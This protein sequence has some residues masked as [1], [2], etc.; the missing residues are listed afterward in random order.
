MIY[1]L[2]GCFIVLDIITGLV[3]ALKNKNYSSTVMREGLFHK[4]S[5]II[6][7]V[8]A[9]II[10]YSSG[11]VDIGFSVAINTPICCYIMLME[12]GSIIENLKEIN[13]NLLTE[14]ITQYFISNKRGE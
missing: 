8:L 5:E 2:V 11:Y 6:V 9:T 7:I 4:V 10:D 3:K 12:I 1:L 14:K 13:P